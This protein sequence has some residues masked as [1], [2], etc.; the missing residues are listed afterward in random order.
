MENDYALTESAQAF[1]GTD[2][3]QVGIYGGA[4]PYTSTVSYPRFKTFKVA[5][6]AVN[7]KLSVEIATE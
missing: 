7:G 3:T 5:D 2:G 1:L 6:K 4:A